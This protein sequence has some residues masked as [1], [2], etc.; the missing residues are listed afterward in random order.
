MRPD[1]DSAARPAPVRIDRTAHRRTDPDW[2]AATWA[3]ALVLVVDAGRVPVRGTPPTIVLLDALDA[4]EGDRYFLGVD[5]AGTAYFAVAATIVAPEGARLATLR[6]VGHELD[7]RDSDLFVTSVALV[8]WHTRTAY[9]PWNG[10]PVVPAE[11]GWTRVGDDGEIMWPRTDPA[12][13]VLVHDGVPGPEGRCLLGHNAAW[14]SPDWVRRYSCLAGFVEAGE[15]AEATVAREVA[16][17]VGVEVSRIRYVGSQAW[18]FPGSLMLGFHAVADP[19]APL[20]PDP[21]EIADARWFSRGEIATA[22]T[23]ERG[24]FGLPPPVSIAHRLIQ[25]WLADDPPSAAVSAGQ[26]ASTDVA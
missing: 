25:T 22:L 10:R 26:P 12:V 6:E 1:D 3:S 18:P 11:G 8:N 13:I 24:D 15:S 4:P 16:E 17:E 14:S 19:A 7:E 20:N 21:A 9:S 23:G 5:A 2:L